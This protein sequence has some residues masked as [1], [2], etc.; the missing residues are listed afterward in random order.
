MI[1]SSLL[2]IDAIGGLA[3]SFCLLVLCN[4][5]RLAWLA[6]RSSHTSDSCF[7]REREHP[8]VLLQI[9][10]YNE[11]RCVEGALTAAARLDWPR[12][13]LQ[14]QLLDD[15]TDETS[16]IA[17]RVRLQLA[18]DGVV[19][20]HVQRP[21]RR[22][23]K[24]GALAEGMALS[25]AP[26][27][28]LLDADFRPP[29]DWLRRAIGRLEE[30]PPAGFV[31][32]R[33][34]YAN[35]S[36]NILTRAQQLSVDTH[37]FVEQAGRLAAGEPFQFNGTAGVWRR[38]ALKDAGGWSG[39]TLTEDLDL[40]LRAALKGWRG[41]LCL[42]PALSGE[43]PSSLRSWKVQQARWSKGFMQVARQALPA[44]WR[45]PWR[46]SRKLAV[47]LFMGMQLVFPCALVALA[48]FLLDA[49]LRG[50][51]HAGHALMAGGAAVMVS[52]IAVGLTYPIHR[53]LRR[54][55][56]LTYAVTIASLLPLLAFLALANSAAIV[57]ALFNDAGEFE[58][59]PKTG[60]A[61]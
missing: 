14:I 59:T 58:R 48:A 32:F 25:K 56:A 4:H 44:I 3:A 26:F 5:V 49:L 8:Q 43:A 61:A 60:G 29:A 18:R 30:E 34:E 38:A 24:A 20:Q 15:S 39:E 22:G 46:V 54:G 35:R 19:I 36:T 50:G 6:C 17:R 27:I 11:P 10:V 47:S 45:S 31:Q 21:T 23:H 16:E 57:R 12:D 55:S 53:Q 37:F 13:K 2:L 52:I 42:H 51:F 7:P 33:F 40:V 41:V 28:A 9:P 1:S